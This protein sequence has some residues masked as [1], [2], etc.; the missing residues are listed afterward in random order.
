SPLNFRSLKNSLQVAADS[1]SPLWRLKTSLCPLS[2]TPIAARTGINSTLLLTRIR[3]LTPSKKIYLTCSLE[4]SLFRHCSTDS[5]SSLFTLLISVAEIDRP[6]SLFESI[7]KLRVLIPARN[8]MLISRAISSSYCL[9]RGITW[10]EYSPL[11]SRGTRTSTLPIPFKAYFLL[12][13]PF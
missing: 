12:Y 7:D 1:L 2:V 3:K 13:E 4:R 10:V 9:L 5:V 11:R 6:I 8:I